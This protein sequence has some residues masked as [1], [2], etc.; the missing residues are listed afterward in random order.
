MYIIDY[1]DKTIAK[2]NNRNLS[3]FLNSG[4]EKNR[5]LFSDNK[6]DAKRIIGI[7]M[8]F[9]AKYKLNKKKGNKNEHTRV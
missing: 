6:Q 1:R 8:G 2:F 7:A 3:E 5:Y 4:F 9:F